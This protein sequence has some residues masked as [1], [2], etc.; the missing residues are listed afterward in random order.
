MAE[1]KQ[2]AAANPQQAAVPTI[3]I[4]GQ[5]VRDMSFENPDAPASILAGGSTPS[6][7]VAINVTV[8]KQQEDIYAVETPI[9]VK[10]E[11]DSKV[12]FNVELIYGGLFRI[13]N[14]PE[15]QIAPILMV[16]CPRLIFPFA[17][18]IVA[19]VSQSGGFPP[20]MLEPVDFAAIYRQNLQRMAQ[21]AQSGQQGAT[22]AGGQSVE[23]PEPANSEAEDDKSGP[24]DA[25]GKSIN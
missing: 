10:A 6:F 21:A 1:D 2:A 18:Q 17:R 15:N 11:R 4:V 3:N 9:N 13:K 16:E 14:V 7:N 8:K 25:G 24:T 12:L 20:V 22:D 19:N 5:Y 23:H